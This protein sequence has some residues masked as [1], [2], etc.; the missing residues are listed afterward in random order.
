[1]DDAL[2]LL[3]RDNPQAEPLSG[4]I[5]VTRNDWLNIAMMALISDGVEQ[6]RIKPLAERLGVSRSS[7][8]WYFKSRE[9]LLD[10]LVDQWMGLN[11]GSLVNAT[12]EEAPTITSA[13]CNVFRSFIDPERFNTQLDF[14]IRDWARR[15]P[16]LRAKLRASDDQ[17]ITALSAM[18][19]RFDYDPLEAETRARMLYYNQI[20]YNDA[21]LHE[22]MAERM[23]FFATYLL[24]FTG[25]A[26][27][28]QEVAQFKQYAYS[29][30]GEE[31]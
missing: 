25:V 31:T 26:P 9:E 20:G 19:Q 16:K 7:F 10:A 23:R 5:K 8:Y 14:T 4:N 30:E 27:D 29:I 12:R 15:D 11:T 17:R 6:V 22:P 3:D 28:P 2:P 1:M 21:D 24:G 13:C 18:F